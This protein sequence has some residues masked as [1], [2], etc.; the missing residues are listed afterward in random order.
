MPYEHALRRLREVPPRDLSLGLHLI[1]RRLFNVQVFLVA[2]HLTR[3]HQ[4]VIGPPPMG[5]VRNSRAS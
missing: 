3:E 5:S 4:R 1:E 2:R